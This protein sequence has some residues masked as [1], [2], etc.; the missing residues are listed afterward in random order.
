MVKNQTQESGNLVRSTKMGEKVKFISDFS[1]GDQFN[2]TKDSYNQMVSSLVQSL[3]VG[4]LWQIAV[5]NKNGEIFSFA[6]IPEGA[7][8]NDIQF[9]NG[10]RMPFGMMESNFTADLPN[11]SKSFYRTLGNSVCIETHTPVIGNKF[12]QDTNQIETV[13]VG[14]TVSR[15][16]L[17]PAFALQIAKLT[18]TEVNLFLADGKTAGGTMADYSNLILDAKEPV[19]FAESLENHPLN[20]NNFEINASG[21]FQAIMPLIHE[22][23]PAAWISITTSKTSITANTQQI[24]IMLSLVFLVCLGVIVPINYVV[25]ASFGKKVNSVVDSLQDIAKGEGDLTRRLKITSKDELGDLAHWFNIFIEKLQSIISDITGNSEQLLNASI[26]L[27]GLSKD[28]AANAKSVSY[29]A[30]LIAT[31]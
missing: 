1:G 21:Y 30:D 8:I 12:N 2:M 3:S 18:K 28:M 22:S 24:A 6:P 13:V 26:N 9:K 4:D 31:S 19:Q 7:S 23:Q 15:T 17:A 11:V 14:V 20:F 10:S 5:Y 29:E 27:T 16:R 25:A